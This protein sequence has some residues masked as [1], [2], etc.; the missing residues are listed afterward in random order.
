MRLLVIMDSNGHF[1]IAH[2]GDREAVKKLIESIND[3][4]ALT[5]ALDWGEIEPFKEDLSSYCCKE[6]NDIVRNFI[7]R[8]T[9]EYVDIPD[10]APK[11]CECSK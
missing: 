2:E 8:G 1:N 5:N 4:D 7:Q 10:V 6:W 11:L 9:M 3:G